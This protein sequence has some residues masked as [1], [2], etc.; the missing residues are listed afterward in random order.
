MS[1]N[2]NHD[3]HSSSVIPEDNGI[4]VMPARA[5]GVGLDVHRSMAQISV[6][7]RNEDS[8]LEFQKQFDTDI[9]SLMEAREWVIKII[10]SKSS[11]KIN[12]S[13]EELTYNIESTAMYHMPVIAVWGGKP[14]V[15]NPAI[16]RTGL[17]KTDKL[18]A[19]NL[20]L[21]NMLGTWPPSYVAPERIQV[22]RMLVAERDSYSRLAT[23]AGNRI[24]SNLLRFGDTSGRE[25]SVTKNQTVRMHVESL[26]HGDEDLTGIH[27]LGIPEQ[28]REMF[29]DEYE[30]YD[31]YM[32][33]VRACDKQII[34][35]VKDMEWETGSGKLK[36]NEM[37]HLLTTVP[38][39]GEYTASIWLCRI[40]TPTRFPNAKAVTAYAG[41]D[42]SLKV[43]AGKVTSAVKR[44]GDKLLHAKLSLAASALLN[45]RSEP[46]GEWGYRIQLTSGRRAK[47]VTGIARRL[48]V[49]LYWV[50]KTGKPFTYEGYQIA[51]EPEV[52]DMTIEELTNVNTAFRRYMKALEKAGIHTTKEM[53][54]EYYICRLHTVKGLGSKFF[55]L[56]KE[57]INNQKPYRKHVK[58]KG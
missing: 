20:C 52:V 49:S 13:S 1:E 56:V 30:E 15:I 26:L 37:L 4:I 36:G 51:R 44:K 43:S 54:H 50:Q 18:D 19:K 45:R 55:I 29:L 8:V 10:T 5:Y 53:V 23:R 3:D 32:E 41:L 9:L 47:A 24:N 31:R 48:A 14:S 58:G 7:V 6:M 33:K 38:G 39:I 12:V 46:F 21:Q 16:A 22:L 25:G 57:F 28:A 35:A 42:P 11:P 40:V 2:N 34:T 17:R 27:T